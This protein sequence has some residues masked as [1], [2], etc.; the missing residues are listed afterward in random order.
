MRIIS[1]KFKNR[2]IY[3][4]TKKSTIKLRPTMEKTREALFNILET[5][6]G[7]G[8]DLKEARVLDGF[9]GLGG[10]GM[11]AL[12]RGAQFVVFADIDPNCLFAIKQTAKSL[13]L[14][15]NEYCTIATNMQRLPNDNSWLRCSDHK[16]KVFKKSDELLE[17]KSDKLLEELVSESQ[18]KKA[19]DMIILDPP[20]KELNIHLELIDNKLQSGYLKSDGIVII[21]HQAKTKLN[22][23]NLK[24]IISRNYGK[25]NISIFQKSND[26]DQ[27]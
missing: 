24:L 25:S 17:R 8:F 18:D 21:E 15:D 26:T 20:Y 1:G 16:A 12:S 19:L 27:K 14:N 10:M 3:E 2:K 5:G 11:E 13:Q 7:I 4:P 23:K 9:C 6:M 22:L